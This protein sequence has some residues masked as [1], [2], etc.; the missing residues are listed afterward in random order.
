MN[1]F[2][3]KNT[4]LHV[5]ERLQNKL[6]KDALKLPFAEVNDSLKYVVDV[7]TN[8]IVWADEGLQHNFEEGLVGQKCYEVLQGCLHPCDFCT[9]HKLIK[10]DEVYTWIHRNDKL[11]QTFLIRD[12]KKTMDGRVFRYEMAIPITNHI[13]EILRHG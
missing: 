8:T 2:K 12:F 10:D 6:S 13:K 11:K 4:P 5:F 9:N 3:R 1:L 7:E